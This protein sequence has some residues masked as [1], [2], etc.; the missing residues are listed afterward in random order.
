MIHTYCAAVTL[1]AIS[2]LSPIGGDRA[3]AAE[4]RLLHPGV[5][6]GF[7]KGVVPQFEKSS[8]HKVTTAAGT[9][10]ALTSRIQKGEAADALI[11]TAEQIEQL[12]TDGKIVS[13]TQVRVAAIGMGVGVRRGQPSRTSFRSTH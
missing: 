8:G 13:G 9:G 11:V 10:G 5:L 1:A 2:F 6:S 12:I 7:V 3:N 4:I